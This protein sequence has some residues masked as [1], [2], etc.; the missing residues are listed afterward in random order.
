MFVISLKDVKHTLT[1]KPMLSDEELRGIVPARFHYLLPLFRE[2]E[3][4]ILAPLR[5]GVDY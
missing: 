5:P 4:N 1:L 2:E 3:A